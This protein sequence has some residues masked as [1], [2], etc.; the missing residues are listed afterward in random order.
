M[1]K[2]KKYRH[3]LDPVRESLHSYIKEYEE[4]FASGALETH[5]EL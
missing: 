3:M 2:W 4:K 1:G 5:E